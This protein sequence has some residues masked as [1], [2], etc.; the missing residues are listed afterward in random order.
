MTNKCAVLFSGGKD[1]CY[2]G[3][4]AKKQGY[5]L[6]CLICVFAENK[7][8]FMFHTPSI[9]Q[10]KKQAKVMQIPI[11]IKKTK[12]EKEKELIDLENAIN[13]AK[14]KF[15]INAV[16][17]GA[18]A[19]KYQ[20]MRI[21]KICDKLNI[22]CIN[23]LWGKNEKKYLDELLENKFKTII[24]GVFAYPFDKSWLGK[25]LNSD[26]INKLIELNKK[27]KIHVAG[28]GGEIETFV[29]D[30]PLFKK[31]LNKS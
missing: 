30:C 15:K 7:E 11:I 9:E 19:S 1:S 5:E 3:Y 4:L 22:K 14:N 20:K 8:S 16:I 12:G 26:T 29:L 6:S 27:Y 10:T 13:E 24:T 2:A 28:E 18:I 21:N 23:P 31:P 17:T 25:E